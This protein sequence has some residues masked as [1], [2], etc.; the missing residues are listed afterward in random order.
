MELLQKMFQQS[1]QT[2]AATPIGTGSL[3]QKGNFLSAL[4][5]K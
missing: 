3:A 2:V 5:V 4:N 1:Q